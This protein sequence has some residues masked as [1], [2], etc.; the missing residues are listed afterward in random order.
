MNWFGQNRWLGTFLIVFGIV[1]IGALYFLFS[2]KGNS[3]GALAKFQESVTEK[4]RLERLDPFPSEA[5][6]RKMKMH[7][8]NYTAALN[9][10]KEELKTRVP[11]EL[12]SIENPSLKFPYATSCT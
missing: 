10:L 9:K 2:A 11:V 1:T 8:E 7:L 6:H 4:N 5:N 12:P 3:D